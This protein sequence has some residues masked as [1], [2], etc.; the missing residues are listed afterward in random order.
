[1]LVYIAGRMRGIAYYNFSAF[2]NAKLMLESQGRTV[3]S[4]ADLDR[5]AG[6][7]PYDSKYNGLYS[8]AEGC[9]NAPDGFDFESCVDRDI[10]AVRMCDAIYMLEGW[11]ESVGA[12]AEKSLAEWLGKKIMLGAPLRCWKLRVSH[13]WYYSCD[14]CSSQEGSH[15]CLLH[16][17]QIKDM[18]LKTC[19][20][21]QDKDSLSNPT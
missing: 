5:Q 7:D 3:I 9:M 17:C 20:D 13:S 1:M 12:R 2:D 19:D 16:T 6:F 4:P 14:F 21:W 11:E 15:Y 18:N 8:T 10:K